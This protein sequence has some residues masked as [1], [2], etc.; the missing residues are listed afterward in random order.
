MYG[1][2]QCG[3]GTDPNIGKLEYFGNLQIV[4]KV[5]GSIGSHIGSS[6]GSHLELLKM[7]TNENRKFDVLGI[8]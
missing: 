8:F 1:N 7:S 5:S 6:I 4:I 2:M 3:G